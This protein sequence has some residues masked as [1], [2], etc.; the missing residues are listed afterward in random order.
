MGFKAIR[1]VLPLKTPPAQKLL[2]LVLAYHA[3]ENLG[4]IYPS[5]G[6]VAALTGFSVPRVKNLLGQAVRAGWVERKRRARQSSVYA[7][8]AS[9]LGESSIAGDTSLP[10]SSIAGSTLPGESSITGDT[11]LPGSSIAGDTSDESSIAGDTGQVSRAIPESFKRQIKTVLKNTAALSASV[12][13]AAPELPLETE[14]PRAAKKAAKPK[15]KT[16]NGTYDLVAT[17]ADCYEAHFGRGYK[18]GGRDF[19]AAKN[20]LAHAA[21][22]QVVEVAIKAWSDLPEG[23]LRSQAVTL[24]GLDGK[25]NEILD[26]LDRKARPK[27]NGLTVPK[28]DDTQWVLPPAGL[29]Q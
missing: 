9:A 20:L 8:N 26:A 11:S 22:D 2:L 18:A 7:L 15:S 27:A 16:P 28:H 3:D 12:S 21:K 6:T 1:A 13:E 10:G 19:R 25:W 17:W 24:Y 4:N 14:K 23:F 29:M 5:I